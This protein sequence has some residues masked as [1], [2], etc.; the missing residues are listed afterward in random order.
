MKIFVYS[1]NSPGVTFDDIKQLIKEE[2]IHVWNL[3]KKGT[4]REIYWRTDGP[5]V[6]AAL[7]CIDVEEAKRII[8]E[9]PLVKV[10]LITFEF[11]PVGAFTP[12][13]NLFEDKGLF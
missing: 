10:G 8:S 1:K 2:M 4:V 11:I 13:E 6:V 3:Y 5:G 9:L 12:L 7:E